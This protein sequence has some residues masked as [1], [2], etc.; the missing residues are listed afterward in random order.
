MLELIWVK[1]TD[2]AWCPLDTVNLEKVEAKGVYIIWHEGDPG[3]VV[4]VGQGDVAT[5]LADH[6]N[7]VDILK[8][9]K[10]GELRVTWAAVSKAQRDGVERYLANLLDPLI[11]YTFPIAEPI[12]VNSP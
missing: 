3:Q 8:Y 1:C 11:G 5:R 7:N 12:E 9:A 4:C 6:R 10:E 2:G